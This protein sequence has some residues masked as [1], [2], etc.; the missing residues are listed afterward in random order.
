MPKITKITTQKKRA[1]RYN[2]YIDHGKGEQYAF[3]VDEEVLIKFQLKKGRELEEFDLADIQYHDEIQKAF[4]MALN[5]LSHR[6]RSEKEVRL[7]L[8][9]K[10]AEE[11]IIQEAIHKL[12]HYKYLDEL[13][14]A[15]AFVRTYANGG[16]KGPFTIDMELKEKGIA[17]S[18]RVQ[19]MNE[20]P[21]DLQIEHARSLAEKS[22]KKEKN[23]SKTALSQKIEQNLLR[24]GF[25]RDIIME[26]LRDVK[27]EKSQ[28]EEWEA[29][30]L[31]AEKI[32]RRN[33]KYTGSEYRQRMKQALYRKGFDIG[34]IDRYLNES[35][36]ID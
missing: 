32:S 22:L 15:K 6:M 36:D 13:E 29:L 4:T 25:S 8:K 34:L 1:D 28:G 7:Y 26:A 2:V 33:Q 27:V 31:Q 10:E 3:S 19:A 9:K 30:S 12:Y 18:V 17:D 5:Y 24:K 11:P 20:Y 16:N 21:I 14:F 23:I 35:E